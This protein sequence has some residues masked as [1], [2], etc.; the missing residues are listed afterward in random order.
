MSFLRLEKVNNAFRPTSIKPLH[1]I[2]GGERGTL[3]VW[4]AECIY[5]RRKRGKGST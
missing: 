4:S 2:I 3:S 5:L 1:A